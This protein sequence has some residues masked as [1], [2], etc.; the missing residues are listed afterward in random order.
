MQSSERYLRI[1]GGG[2]DLA[3]AA[4]I[5]NIKDEKPLDLPANDIKTPGAINGK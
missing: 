4:G 2:K 3:T 1:S 5:A